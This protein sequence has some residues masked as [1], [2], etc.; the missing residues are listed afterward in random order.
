MKYALRR[1]GAWLV[2]LLLAAALLPGAALARGVVDITRAEG[3]LSIEYPCPGITFR[4]YRVA[5]LSAT[6][7]FHLTGEFQQ[8]PISLEG[9]D[10]AG[11]R[12]LAAT[13]S[14]YA[15]R[16]GLPP[17][18]VQTT[19]R[20]G[21]LTF[22]GKTPGLYLVD[23]DRHITGGYRYTPQPF[24][25]SLPGLDAD[26]NWVYSVTAVPKYDRDEVPVDPPV[27]PDT[28]TRRVL[29]IWRDGGEAAARPDSVTVQLL[30]NGAVYE[31]VTLSGA[32]GWAYEW[33]GLDADSTWQVVEKD[34][35]EGYT[36][37]VGR[38]GITFT[39]TNTWTPPPPPGPS[40]DPDSP[41]DTPDTSDRP[42]VPDTPDAPN[43]PDAPDT[44]DT[45][46]APDIPQTGQLW[47]PAPVLACGGMGLFLTGWRRR[48]KDE[49][50][51]G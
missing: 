51:E 41:P 8:Y 4:L 48:K 1:A 36:V 27:D 29:K 10:S 35:P 47:W 18:D 44:P 16:D 50:D 19:D 42:D 11:W 40:D 7:S 32:D 12:D 9:L 13:L 14:G 33:K 28:V 20:A 5:E 39:V 24:L 21:R 30:Q 26:D 23:W 43:G 25:I 45:P 34:V 3:A 17:A 46:D 38:S 31:E 15:A 49:R 2:C 6:G 22:S 37:S